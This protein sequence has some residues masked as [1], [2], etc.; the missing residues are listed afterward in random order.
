MLF[1]AHPMGGQETR[2]RSNDQTRRPCC[3]QCTR[4]CWAQDARLTW[5]RSQGW[6]NMHHGRTLMYTFLFSSSLAMHL[7][8]SCSVQLVHPVLLIF[9][10]RLCRSYDCSY[11]HFLSLWD[12]RYA[13]KKKWKESGQLVWGGNCTKQ[14]DDAEIPPLFRTFYSPCHTDPQLQQL[15]VISCSF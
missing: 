15:H 14:S 6:K 11:V 13:L 8:K 7:H 5:I 4:N 1:L 9:S 3:R 2:V 10:G 12:K